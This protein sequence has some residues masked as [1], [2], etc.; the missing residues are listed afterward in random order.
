MEPPHVDLGPG[1]FEPEP[2]AQRRHLE[3]RLLLP[4]AERPRLAARHLRAHLQLYADRP[5]AEEADTVLALQECVVGAG[6][7]IAPRSGRADEP[8]SAA[9]GALVTGTV[10]LQP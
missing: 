5:E 1:P 4:H 8:P 10:P 7:T 2:P 9:S 6:V 3:V